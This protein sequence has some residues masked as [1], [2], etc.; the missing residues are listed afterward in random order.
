MPHRV[1]ILVRSWTAYFPDCWV[2]Y[3]I[4]QIDRCIHI[5]YVPL[6][7]LFFF[8]YFLFFIF[9]FMFLSL[10]YVFVYVASHFMIMKTRLR[11]ADSWTSVLRYCTNTL[12]LH[13]VHTC[14]LYLHSHTDGCKAEEEGV[15]SAVAECLG[16]LTTIHGER[17][18]PTLIDLSRDVEEKL[19]R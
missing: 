12:Y 3:T 16:V 7:Y 11:T 13:T 9:H 2:R 6:F 10:L 4:S 8:N 18:V 17:L 19:T 14:T 5:I 15:R 1:W